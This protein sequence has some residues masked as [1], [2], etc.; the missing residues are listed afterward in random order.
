VIR[1][2]KK[3]VLGVLIDAVDY[4]AAI[5][6]VVE[7]AWG[8][9][10]FSVTAL[11]VHGVMEGVMDRELR[12]RLNSTDLVTPDGQP[13]RWAMNLLY[14]ASLEDRVYGPELTLRICERA[15]REG[16]P[17]YFYGG[18]TTILDGLRRSVARR[19]PRLIVA[20]MEASKFRKITSEEKQTVVARILA[21]GAAIVFVGLGCPRQEIW[22]YEFRERL[23]IPVLA[24][25]AAF[26]FL[27]GTVRQ[28]PQWMGRRGL[29]WLYRLVMEP[30]RLWRR[31]ILLN[32]SYLCLLLLQAGRIVRFSDPGSR[33]QHDVSF[34]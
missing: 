19:F 10:P 25:G 3:N 29:E 14:G 9:R 34:G 26:P 11:A 21:S 27:A 17:V 6:A 8:R 5:E 32:P 7:A 1:Q 18:T 23:S 24:V 30:R 20:G 33:P 2:G 12:H 28:A 15:E 16:L 22:C 4:E 13:V 31:Y